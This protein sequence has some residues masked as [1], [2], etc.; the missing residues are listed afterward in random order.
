[1]FRLENFLD[2][3][4]LAFNNLV[5]GIVF[6]I[7]LLLYAQVNKTLKGLTRQAVGFLLLSIGFLLL[8]MRGIVADFLSII[9]SNALVALGFYFT[10][11]SVLS[12]L[13]VER[14]NFGRFS[15]VLITLVA[16]CFVYFTYLSPSVN[17]RIFII[18]AFVSILSFYS[19]FTL[20]GIRVSSGQIFLTVFRFVFLAMAALFSARGIF[21]LTEHRIS[22]FMNA[23]TWHGLSFI[24]F[25]L[26]FIIVALST[27]GLANARLSKD[28]ET[29]ATLDPLTGLNNR[30][31]LNKSAELELARC[32]RSGNIFSL[33]LID[34]DY[35]KSINDNYGHQ[36]GDKVLVEF[37]SWLRSKVRTSDFV[38]RFGGE[39][40]V[41]L[42]NDIDAQLLIQIAQELN[43]KI[44]KKKFQLNECNSM[45]ITISIGVASSEE[46]E[47]DWSTILSVA[48]KRLYRAK[49]NGR[50]RVVWK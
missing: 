50:N 15:L 39:E 24:A 48:D 18:S 32:K 16:I 9:V 13:A 43:E 27:S 14:K 38:A 45:N 21:S 25:E 46:T 23:G 34:I 5:T 12:F 29:Q 41:I 42:L 11:Q 17:T 20:K 35:F 44:I 36:A 6:G 26:M 10:C 2:L 8:G 30:R 19:Y 33:V 40:F 31:S 49:E 22:D 47:L 1:M 3:R 28:L 37:A 4:T 7:G